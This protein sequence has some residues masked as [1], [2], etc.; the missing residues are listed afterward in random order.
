M[1][2]KKYIAV[3]KEEYKAYYILVETTTTT[4]EDIQIAVGLFKDMGAFNQHV[5]CCKQALASAIRIEGK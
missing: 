5:N 3:W 1:A 2:K 4:G